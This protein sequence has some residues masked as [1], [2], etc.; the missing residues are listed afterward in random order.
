MGDVQISLGLLPILELSWLFLCRFGGDKLPS[1]DLR[2][3]F[4]VGLPKVNWGGIAGEWGTG[5]PGCI[6]AEWDSIEGAWT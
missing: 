4:A 3:L 1:P 6:D 2:H 5:G